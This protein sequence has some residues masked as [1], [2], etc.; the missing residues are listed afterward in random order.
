[1][2]GLC[3]L[4]FVAFRVFP[5][6]CEYWD[7]A[8]QLTAKRLLDGQPTASWTVWLPG[9]AL[10]LLVLGAVIPT[11]YR[12]LGGAL[13]AAGSLIDKVKGLLPGKGGKG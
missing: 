8:F 9:L 12:D 11:S 7:L 6:M 10:F 13:G 4:G 3:A 5:K 1:L 2:T